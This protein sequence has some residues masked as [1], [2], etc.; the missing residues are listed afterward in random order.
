M[1][2][3]RCPLLFRTFLYRRYLA[4]NLTP[5]AGVAAHISQNGQPASPHSSSCILSPLPLSGDISMPVTAFGCFL[6][7]HNGGR[8][9]FKHQNNAAL[10]KLQPDVGNQL[11]EA[12]NKEL[13]SCIRD[14]YIEMV[15]EFQK[16]KRDPLASSIELSSARTA[17]LILQAYADRIYSFWPRSKQHSVSHNQPDA[18]VSNSNSSR[19]AEWKCLVEQVI[20]PFYSR[21]VDLPV[22]QLYCGNV[23]KADEGMFLAQS[24]NGIG[25][26]LPPATVCNFIKEHYP[27]FSVPWELVSEIRAV[28]VT[29][30]EIKPKMVRNLLKASSTSIVLRAVETYIDVLEYCLGDVQLQ[31]SSNL[32]NTDQSGGVVNLDPLDEVHVSEDII[33]HRNG[34][35][36]LV[37]N[38][39]GS[40]RVVMQS[41]D[42]LEMMTNLGKALFDFGRVV[43]EDI[44]RAGGHKITMSSSSTDGE[45]LPSL[46]AEFNGLP[47]P[48]ATKH[49]A[50]LGVT[51]L[52]VGSKE[53]QLLML[54]LAAKFIHPLCLERSNLADFLCN[55]SIHRF[56]KL[57][58][59]SPYLLSNN[60]KLL[61]SKYW[62]NHVMD[63]KAP[64][65]SW[66]NGTN[67][68]DG[69]PS[70]EWIRLFWKSFGRSTDLSLFSDWPLIP[71]F[72]GRPILCRVKEHHLVFIPPIAEPP[73]DNGASVLSN[74]RNEMSIFENRIAEP[75]MMHP[76]LREFENI[77]S[78]HPWLFSLLNQCNIP[79][80]DMSFLDS[81]MPCNCLPIP[82]HTLG[83]VIVSKLL[84]AKR[85]G[86]FSVPASILN[87][88]R[89]E[90]FTLF[91]SDFSP[92]GSTYKSEELD[93]LCD[94]P[95]YKTVV[96]TYTTLRGSDQC[97]ISPNSIFQPYDGR[98]LSNSVDPNGRLLFRALGVPELH[99]QEILV[100]FS[101]PGFEQMTQGEQE[102]ILTYI[103][104]NWQGLQLDSAVVGA[105][106]ETKFV[107]NGNADSLEL[108][109]PRDL[110]D[111][112]DSLLTSVFSRDRNRFPG[113]RF[114]SSGWLHILRKTGLRT[115]AEA[116][117]ILECA[118]NVELLGRQAIKCVED[119]GDF[120]ADL[121]DSL[122]EVPLEIWLLA[123]SVVEAIF[124][125]F[126]VLYGNH[127]CDQ[128]SKIAF[129]PAEKGLPTIGG[130]TGGRRFLSSYSEA[131]LLKDWPLAWSSSPILSKMNVIP[132]E[133]SWGALH[134]RGPPAF[135]TVL[136]HLQVVELFSF[137]LSVD[138]SVFCL[139]GIRLR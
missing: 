95:I 90:L 63:S 30:R 27:V 79:V 82:G 17:S 19:E 8:Y 13:M 119:P 78:R 38:V 133:Y 113:E 81:G 60:M 134:L 43:V 127:F 71:A 3:D 37:S 94:L 1:E 139:D 105:L 68:T 54:P 16:L 75:D 114:T 47:C 124:T 96:G 115:S 117:M 7:S 29:V 10:S 85:A 57:Q 128:L 6:V 28:G 41:P 97:I 98:C 76:Y 25:D 34:A 12:W 45:Q 65:F 100:R 39:R 70:T 49:L 62:V 137:C 110:L 122:N 50:R 18:V 107:Q 56:L 93:V 130:R 20:R 64:W 136:K 87:E 102:V 2:F 126:A 69:G 106:K 84:A 15:L 59:F 52:W 26:N 72:L 103:H 112:C 4:Y 5:V 129:V 123:G 14:S 9:L 31:P 33:M 66:D 11:I 89:D 118:R 42:A 51:E 53:H 48:T 80:Y 121:S 135:S 83:Q 116:D 104:M 58:S 40:D 74:E 21:L 111:P 132:P 32:S 92:S 55:H 44:G 101:L 125:N 67:V 131:I 36:S 138:M 23:V 91:A 120:E 73:L 108:F 88:D 22:W 35:P 99:D 109:R 86:Y 77:K 24:G 61:F 46:A